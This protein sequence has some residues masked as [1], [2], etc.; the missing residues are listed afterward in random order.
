MQGV[1]AGGRPRPARPASR[2]GRAPLCAWRPRCMSQP[3]LAQQQHWGNENR[4]AADRR[5]A[6]RKTPLTAPLHLGRAAPATGDELGRRLERL[7]GELLYKYFS[8]RQDTWSDLQLF[9]ILNLLVFLSGAAVYRMLI[10]SIDSTAP[11]PGDAPEWWSDLYQGVLAVVLGQA[12]P[13]DGS[14]FPSQAF[15][16]AISVLGLA[17]FALVLAL[18]EQVVLEVLER[19]VRQGS[20]VYESGHTVVLAWCSSEQELS[21]LH[22]ILEQFC[23]AHRVGAG[24]DVVVVLTQQRE[25]LEMESIF[26]EAIPEERRHGVQFVFRQGSPLDPAALRMVAVPSAKS[27]V[28]S[29]DY[30]RAPVES[31]AQCVRVAV[32]LDEMCCEAHGTQSWQ[33]HESGAGP[34]IVV[35]VKTDNGLDLLRYS[36]SVRV[37]PVATTELNVQRLARLLRHP[38][39]ATFTHMLTDYGSLAHAC[40]YSFPQ[41]A[42][43]R[44]DSLYAYFPY[45]LVMGVQSSEEGT[46]ELLPAPSRVVQPGE[47]L[48]MLSP[49]LHEGESEE[50]PLEAPL[51]PQPTRPWDPTTYVLRSKDDAPL[52][53]TP[54]QAY[55][56]PP[57]ARAIAPADAGGA[58][59]A[60]GTLWAM[61]DDSPALMGSADTGAAGQ[62]MFV[63]PVP[64]GQRR[65]PE[66]RQE[67]DHLLIAG[68]GLE[69]KM[70]ALLEELDHGLRPL[71]PGS[72]ITLVNRHTW[73]AGHLDKER[74]AHSIRRLSVQHVRA[75]PRDEKE[76]AAAVDVSTCG[77]AIVLC[78]RTWAPSGRADG[79]SGGLSQSQML[80]MDA[81]ALMVQLTIRRLLDAKAHSTGRRSSTMIVVEKTT[82]AGGLTRFEDTTRPPLGVS[83]NMASY[84]AKAL[85]HTALQPLFKDAA[86]KL[87]RECEMSVQ[88]SSAFAFEGEKI[89]FLALQARVASV[90]QM[91]MG[92]Y[93][94]P[95]TA[96]QP[97]EVVVNPQGEELRTRRQVFNAGDGRC[98]LLTLAKVSRRRRCTYMSSSNA[99]AEVGAGSPPAPAA[100]A[101]Q[102][103]ESASERR[104]GEP[105]SVA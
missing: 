29:G 81:N 33:R 32:L 87:G 7:R 20:T 16:V 99:D 22:R 50:L 18:M 8:W 56:A 44:F 65:D 27:I 58:L 61:V 49:G 14:G 85:S 105:A 12:L 48:V 23:E 55:L 26:R 73:A 75:D 92:Y 94:L 100:P 57:R 97:L 68:W 40:L 95:A 45:S 28:V 2:Q 88:D 76:L 15:A 89:S 74:A 31:D 17:S 83:V 53:A 19:N 84:S 60:W 101:Q 98:K 39:A 66:E 70:W 63:L 80:R 54:P 90:R 43:K 41:L 37:I 64:L 47:R 10:R 46:C 11:P 69:N 79:V 51:V 52:G 104:H 86:P 91:L 34:V 38:I 35:Q 25:K 1:Q 42:G 78:D 82:Y 3:I 9:M 30:A 13:P 102:R 36:C 103:Q 59:S 77:A 67:G 5:P 6:A 96:E 21:Q 24:T 62:Q 4:L 93:R 71:P 72:R